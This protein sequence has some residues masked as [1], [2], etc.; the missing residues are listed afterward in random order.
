MFK[1]FAKRL[2]KEIKKNVDERLRITEE[3]NKFKPQPIDVKVVSHHM[4]RY[5]VWFGGSMIATTDD[6]RRVVHTKAEYYEHGPSICR[7]N[8]IFAAMSSK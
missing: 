1:G 3:I 5:A 2:T 7:H 6:F 4:Q 8:P